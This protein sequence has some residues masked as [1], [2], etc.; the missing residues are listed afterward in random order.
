MSKLLTV[1][2][3]INAD[4]YVEVE[5]LPK[6][7]ETIIGQDAAFRPGGKGANQAAAA[8]RLG[9]ETWLSGNLGSDAFAPP[10]RQALEG[11]GVKVDL[12]NQVDGPTGQA[13]ILLQQGGENSIIVVA[14]ANREWV[15]L[16]EATRDSIR[17]SG[18]LLL[19]RE[20]P[21]D[22]N[23]EAA[24]IAHAAGVPVILDAG[25]SDEP[26]S[27]ELMPLITVLS[28]NETEL[29]RLTGMPTTTNEQVAAAARRLQDLGIGSVLVKL[30]N[31]GAMLV[32]KTGK[33]IVHGVFKV[34][35]VD[36]T[37]AGDCFT[38]A[39][40]AGLVGGMKEASCVRF[41]CAAAAMSVQKKGAL[42]SMPSRDAVKRFLL[43]R[44][45]VDKPVEYD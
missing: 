11:A 33:L 21:E 8:A 16:D 14:G 41:A 40:A 45:T 10:L 26:L 5:R 29:A 23:L 38:A 24:H 37:G 36:T 28:P 18:L 43:T 20:I 27:K 31:R 22:I 32:P 35:V 6:P 9:I 19:Q 39:F 7:G 12:V 3:S 15:E 2:G 13:I 34:K 4:L 1:V 17:N 44:S 25:G 42:P 30:G